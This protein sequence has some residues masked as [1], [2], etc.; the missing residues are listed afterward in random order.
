MTRSG[1]TPRGGNNNDLLLGEL[2]AATRATKEA[3]QG[4]SADQKDQ[5]KA[6]ATCAATLEHVTK[7]VDNLSRLVKD[8]NGDSLMTRV[9]IIEET[10]IKF[11]AA[12]SLGDETFSHMAT[13]DAM[14]E[15]ADRIGEVELIATKTDG[16]VRDASNFWSSS[17]HILIGLAILFGWLITTGIALYAV[18]K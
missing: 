11:G 5:A 10:L 8:G 15:L 17:K 14:Q 13:K 9:R 6:L 7:A 16:T 4:L 2:L 18:I 1:E 12:L 3:I